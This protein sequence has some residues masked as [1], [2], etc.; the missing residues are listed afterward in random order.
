[1]P[2][3]EIREDNAKA[4]AV[5]V[6]KTKRQIIAGPHMMIHT[7]AVPAGIWKGRRMFGCAMRSW[8]MAASSSIKAAQ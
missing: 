1:M 8:I 4:L 6:K 2:T 5:L 7:P 3:A